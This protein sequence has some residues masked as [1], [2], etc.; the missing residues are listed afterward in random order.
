MRKAIDIALIPPDDILNFCIDLSKK[1]GVKDRILHKEK[2]IPHITLLMGGAEEKDLPRI[3]EKI[4][5]IVS[6]FKA[7]DIEID[8]AKWG[9]PSGLNA[10]KSIKLM[11]LHNILVKKVSP[12]FHYHNKK[13]VF[14]SRPSKHIKGWVNN[15]LDDSSKENFVP[16]ITLGDANLKK[17]DV[18]LPIKF[19][20]SRIALCYVGS[21]GTCR[22]I[23][24]ETKLK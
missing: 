23:F 1:I 14:A 11:N 10:K 18:E 6:D 15:F 3:W 12:L 4:Q 7:I 8:A 19:K 16:H 21:H 5:S 17:E 13:I 9:N 20:A 24:Y 22:R 2:C